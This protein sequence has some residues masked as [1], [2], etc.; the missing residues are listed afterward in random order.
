M[1]DAAASHDA[2]LSAFCRFPHIRGLAFPGTLKAASQR[3]NREEN[4][5]TWHKKIVR[6]RGKRRFKSIHFRYSA[7]LIDKAVD[8]RVLEK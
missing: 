2:N 1:V 5:V 8:D 4:V 3:Q 7:G 6:H